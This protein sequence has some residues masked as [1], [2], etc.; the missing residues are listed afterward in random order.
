MRSIKKTL[1]AASITGNDMQT[2]LAGLLREYR[3]TPNAS[4]FAPAQIMF[5]HRPRTGLAPE[6]RAINDP[7][8]EMKKNMKSNIEK[9]MNITNNK[10]NTKFQDLLQ[11]QV[12]I[13]KDFGRR[14]KLTPLFSE[15]HF[16][17]TEVK[18]SIMTIT[19]KQSGKS[20]R[21]HESSLKLVTEKA[22]FREIKQ[23]KEKRLLYIPSRALRQAN[24]CPPFPAQLSGAPTSTS[25]TSTTATRTIP[26]T[27]SMLAKKLTATT[28]RRQQQHY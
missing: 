16:T 18:G 26:A 27:T 10:I 4:G 6:T 19:G 25:L 22:H 28:T 3:D 9:Q 14:T 23:E 17:I 12:V 15:E 20:Y 5:R 8:A 1:M 13:M 7:T 2:A 24:P 11:G 21:R